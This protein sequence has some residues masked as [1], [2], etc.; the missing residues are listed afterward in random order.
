MT[1]NPCAIQQDIGE[2]K[3]LCEGDHII[4]IRDIILAQIA[5]LKGP[6]QYQQ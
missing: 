1:K 6:G 3:G 5:R 4:L 2:K